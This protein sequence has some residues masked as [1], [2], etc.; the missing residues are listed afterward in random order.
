MDS[1]KLVLGVAPFSPVAL[2]PP[3]APV[4]PTP[5]IASALAPVAAREQPIKTDSEQI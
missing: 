1:V 3:L 5:V 4:A 2:S